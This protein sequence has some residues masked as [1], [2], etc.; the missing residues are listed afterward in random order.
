MNEEQNKKPLILLVGKSG[1]GKTT[2]AEILEKDYHLKSL[3]SYTTRQPRCDGKD[4][5]TFV[6]FEEYWMLKNK[7]ATTYFKNNYY[8][9]TKKQCDNSDVYVVDPSGV[10][11]FTLNYKGNRVPLIIYINTNFFIRFYRMI[12]RGDSF[13]EAIIEA[14]GRIRHDKTKF[15]DFHKRQ[16]VIVIKNNFKPASTTAL[17]I[18]QEYIEMSTMLM[19]TG[20]IK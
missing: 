17:K 1:S 7:V 14:I 20:G 9:A 4:D 18:C 10:D 3:R 5:H 15:G 8:C 13:I 6:T 16:N 2:I 11:V 12:R 19:K